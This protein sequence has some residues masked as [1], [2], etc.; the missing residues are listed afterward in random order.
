MG[1]SETILDYVYLASATE[2]QPA[3]LVI[4]VLCECVG[5]QSGLLLAVLQQP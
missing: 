4:S 5:D 1:Q 2:M 3:H